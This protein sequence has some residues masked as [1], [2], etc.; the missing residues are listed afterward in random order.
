MIFN[1]GSLFYE[2]GC[3]NSYT[4][5][6]PSSVCLAYLFPSFYPLVVSVID[7]SV[8]FLVAAERYILFPNLLK[9]KVCDFFMGN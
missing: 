5:L 6:F 4:C 7:S 3:S 8:Y 2:L 9:K 1:C